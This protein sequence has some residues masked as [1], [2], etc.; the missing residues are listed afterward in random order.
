[1]D[2]DKTYLA[3]LNLRAMTMIESLGGLDISEVIS[4]L[5]LAKDHAE[6]L[7]AHEIMHKQR[8]LEVSMNMFG[9][10]AGMPMPMYEQVSHEKSIDGKIDPQTGVIIPPNANGWL[11]V[12]PKKR[13]DGPAWVKE[14]VAEEG[15]P[16]KD[17]A[18]LA[19]V[20]GDPGLKQ[21]E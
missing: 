20:A 9:A 8:G 15:T 21:G 5:V 18:G 12:T 17:N 10:M 7:R 2:I 6:A 19:G 13:P 11:E 1:M 16:D 3:N 14:E 4:V